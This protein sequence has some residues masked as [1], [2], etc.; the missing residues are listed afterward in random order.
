MKEKRELGYI[1]KYPSFDFEKW[2][3]RNK[4]CCKLYNKYFNKKSSLYETILN[5]RFNLYVDKLFNWITNFENDNVNFSRGDI[6]GTL[7]LIKTF[8]NKENARSR[9]INNE[10]LFDSRLYSNVEDEL[11][12]WKVCYFHRAIYENP[13][14]VRR[15]T[16][17]IFY[18][19]LDLYIT[20]LKY[21]G[22]YNLSREIF[23]GD[24]DVSKIKRNS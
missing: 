4:N 11:D 21:F 10:P 5:D 6:K 2:F 16:D 14:Y 8:S 22:Y 13:I 23:K 19:E 15:Y 24:D 20:F 1:E 3:T 12:F 9:T 7:R 17:A 18:A